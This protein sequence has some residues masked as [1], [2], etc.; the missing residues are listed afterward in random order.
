MSH[1]RETLAQILD[2]AEDAAPVRSLDVVAGHLRERFAARQVS[3]LFPDVVGQ[4]VVRVSEAS[5]A[6]A[7][8]DDEKAV[9]LAGSVYDEVLRTQR[10]S[11][12]TGGAGEEWVVAPVTNRG[13]TIGLLELRLEQV[14]EEMLRQVGDAAHALAYIVVTDRRFT[15]LY[16]FH[17]RT[18]PF[19]LAAE[20]Q[21]QLLPSAPSC[22][23]A[24]FA[25]A[26][27]LLPADDVGGDTYDYSLDQD[28][29]H[30]SITDAMGHDTRSALLATL[31]VNAAR[32]ARRAGMGLADQA[33]QIHRALKEHGGGALATG[34]LLCIRLDGGGA[35]L[36][37]AGHPW[38]LR[39]R[40]GRVEEVRLEIDLPFGVGRT[41]PG[42]HVQDIDLRPGDRLLL[43]TDGVQDRG[44]AS[45]ALPELLSRTAGEHPREVVRAL[46]AAV[47]EASG[48]RLQDDATVLCLDW[49]GPTGQDRHTRAGSELRP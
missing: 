36:V 18:T 6:P 34:Q 10:I 3:F 33:E 29:L 42:Y 21:H 8:P 38:P 13:D 49:H 11:R 17:R 16:H 1:S 5:A 27:A 22:E 2:A 39:L 32:G 7:D 23:A 25:L 31:L 28:T 12:R 15:D 26:G 35:Q 30:L 46:A 24:Q 20:I 47:V 9:A 41:S 19:S 4:R 44:A 37:N 40:G 48:G 14:T 45:V 43:Y